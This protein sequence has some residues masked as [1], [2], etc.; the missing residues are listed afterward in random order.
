MVKGACFLPLKTRKAPE[1]KDFSVRVQ[2]YNFTNHGGA[3]DVIRSL[4]AVWNQGVS[5]GWNQHE[6]MYVINPKERYTLA[7]DAMPILRI[8]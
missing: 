6:V 5:L 4:S 3:V 8:G 2:N 1:I 7:R